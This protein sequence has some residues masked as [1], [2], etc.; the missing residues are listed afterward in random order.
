MRPRHLV[1]AV[2]L[3]ATTALAGTALSQ[4][5]DTVRFLSQETDPDVVR[6]Q[7]ASVEKFFAENPGTDIILE[8]APNTVSKQRIAT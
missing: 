5:I 2:A 8:S 6:A 4:V 7:R 3:L 1:A